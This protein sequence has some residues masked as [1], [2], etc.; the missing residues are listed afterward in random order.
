MCNNTF[1]SASAKSVEY[2]LS[3]SPRLLPQSGELFARVERVGLPTTRIPPTLSLIRALCWTERPERFSGMGYRL[4]R[5][6]SSALSSRD[7]QWKPLTRPQTIGPLFPARSIALRWVKSVGGPDLK[8][9]PPPYV[10]CNSGAH[11]NPCLRPFSPGCGAGGDP[12]TH[13]SP[14]CR[15]FTIESPGLS[16]YVS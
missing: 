7:Y 16:F 2:Y 3:L 11:V 10:V 5:S 13:F 12:R 8:L 15:G 6:R 4:H 14:L 1:C 9:A